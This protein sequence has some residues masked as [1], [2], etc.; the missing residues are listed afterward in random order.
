[1]RNIRAASVQFEH[2]AGDKAANFEKIRRYAREAAA[3]GVEILA[4]PEC[5]ITG[6]W[7]LRNQS[8][9]QLLDLAEPVPEGPST[10]AL[11]ELSAEHRMTIG[12]GLV[13]LDQS[14]L[15][16]NTYVIAMP[17][18]TWRRHRKIH[19]FESDHIVPGS[20]FTVFD[21]PHG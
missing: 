14:G 18:G 1:M 21:T 4:F 10:R 8:R 11:L 2:A 5:C 3:L 7:F 20:E 13:E 16:R 15:M 19:A 6:Y 9:G 12:A 17:D